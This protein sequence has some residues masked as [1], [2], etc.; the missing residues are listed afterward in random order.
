[1]VLC[2]VPSWN[3]PTCSQK[4]WNRRLFTIQA[5]FCILYHHGTVLYPTYLTSWIGHLSSYL[6]E[7]CYTLY[8]HWNYS[9]TIV[10]LPSQNS[11]IS[12]TNMKRSFIQSTIRSSHLPSKKGSVSCTIN[13]HGTVLHL[14]A[15]NSETVHI[16]MKNL[17]W[18]LLYV[19]NSATS[20]WSYD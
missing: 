14:T 16:I 8:H 15:Y 19:W 5:W 18:L 2:P 10:Y 1:M 7:W 20:C 9:G 6:L 4:F 3:S 17:A 12:Y 11:P 13:H